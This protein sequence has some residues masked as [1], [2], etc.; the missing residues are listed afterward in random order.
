MKTYFV[1]LSVNWESGRLC[2]FTTPDRD[3][4]PASCKDLQVITARSKKQARINY[5]F[6]TV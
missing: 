3:Q 5:L 4:I 1:G 2:M 6:E